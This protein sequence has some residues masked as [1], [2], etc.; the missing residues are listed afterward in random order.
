V[1]EELEETDIEVAKL[2]S[3]F[4]YY[5]WRVSSVRMG[6]SSAA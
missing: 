3:F 2:L 4:G 6:I 1:V 5:S